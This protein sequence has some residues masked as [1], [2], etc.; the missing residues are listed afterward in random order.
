V[1]ASFLGDLQQ[2]E[3]EEVL[4]GAS[5]VQVPAGATVLRPGEMRLWLIGDGL[6][7]IFLLSPDGRQRSLYHAVP[8][9]TIGLAS[10]FLPDSNTGA[11]AVIESWL[12]PLDWERLRS[13]TQSNSVLTRAISRE[14]L[15]RWQHI[16]EF[17][18]TRGQQPVRQRIC[19]YLLELLAR[20][21]GTHGALPLTQ[22]E[23]ADAIGASREAVA[24]SLAVLRR[25]G[26]IATGPSRI[27]VLDLDGLRRQV[28]DEG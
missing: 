24:R 13:L 19:A 10:V 14:I 22:Q 4:A 25:L 9:E 6:I 15:Q 21:P 1:L 3:A 28:E 27:K 5:L 7:Q 2:R 12:L 26:L 8:G 23:L 20:L 16:V 17:M 18:A 11:Q